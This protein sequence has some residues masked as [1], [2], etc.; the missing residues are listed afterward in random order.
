MADSDIL[1]QGAREHNLREVSLVLPRNQLICFTGVSGSGKSSLAFDTLYAEGQRRYVE[2]LSSFARQF[3]GQMP[4][5]DVDLIAGLSPAISI[6][7]KSSGT[8]PRSTVGTI[9]EI[10]DYLRV[11]FARVGKGHCP[12]CRRPI[13]AQTRVQIIDR[14]GILATG[15]RFL[16][17]APLIRGQ[18][19]EYRDLFEDLLKQGFVRAR[20]DGRVVRLTDDLR[21]DR[22]MRHNIEVVVDRLVAGP[23]LRPRLAE[24]VEAALRLGEGNLIVAADEGDAEKKEGGDAETRRR[25]DSET[26]RRGEEDVS[27]SAR[28][29]LS[30]SLP[31]VPASLASDLALSAHYACTHCQ[32]SFEPPSPQLFSFNSPQGM[33]PE[34]SGLGQIYSFDP[35]RLI[36]D[37]SRSFQQ[38]CIE[39]LGKWREMG[40]WKRHIFRGVAETLERRYGLPPG[41]VLE[42]AWEELD[43][44]ARHA[45][46]WGTGDEHVTFTWRGGASGYKWGGTFEGIIPKFL[47]QYRNTRSRPQRRQLEKYMRVLGCGRCQGRRLNAQAC[48]VTITTA[49]EFP[50]AVREQSL[51]EVCQLSVSAAAD[52]LSALKLDA[53]GATIAAEAVKEIRSRLQFLKNVGLEYLA[54]DRTAPTLSGGEMQRIRLAGQI[55]CGLVGV[56]YIL[57]EPSIGLHPRDNDKLL[58]TLAQLRDQ[59]NTVVVVEHDED[60]MRAAD[61]IVDFGPGPGVRGGNVVAAGSIADV[62]AAEESLTGAYLS[63]RR[64]IDVPAVRRDCCNG[65]GKLA[66]RGARHNNLKN[67]DVE[68][69]LGVFVCVTGV[70]GSGKSSLVN[71]ILVETLRRDLNAG[72]G[73]PGEFDKLEGIEHLDKM[74]AIDQSP[75]GRTPRSNPATYIKVFDEIRRLYTQLPEAKAKGFEPGRFSFNVSGGRCE[76]CE[77]NGSTK[78]EMDFLADIWVTC[79]VCEGHRFNRETLQVRYKGKSIAEVLEM[80]VQEALTHFENIPAVADKLRTLHAVGLDYVKLGQPSPTLSGGEAQRIKLARELVKKSTGRTLYLLDEPTTGLHFADIQLLLTVLHGFVEAGNTVLVVE[81]NTEVIKTADWIIDLGPEGGAGGGQIIATGTPEQVAENPAS[82]TGQV[83]KRWLAKRGKGERE[84]GRRGEGEKS[85]PPAPLSP[86]PTP[87]RAELAKAIKVRGARQHNLKGIDVDIP[88]DQMTVCCGP[89]GSGKT[90]LA[91]DTIYAEGQRRY[92]ESLSSYARQFV[93]KMQKPRLDHIEGLSPAIAIEQKHAGHSPRSTVGTV[94]EIYDYLR[95]I[96]SRLGQPYC[97]ACDLRV[98]TQTADEIIDKIMQR[99]A[100]TRLYLMAPLEIEVGEKYEVLW[101]ELLAAGYVRVR[102]DGQTHTL[103]QMPQI[104]RR[105]KHDVEVVIDRVTVWPDG[106]SPGGA[107]GTPGRSRVAGSVE[108]ALAKGRGVLRVTEPRD[109]VPEARWPVEVHSQ[110]FACQKCGRSFEPLSPHNFSFNSTLGWC[111]AC[112]GLG[113]QT[114]TNPAALLRDPKLSLAQGAVG[115]W[116]GASNRLFQR[117]LESFT[118]GAGIPIDVPYDQLGGK[119][120]RLIMHG[121]GDQWFDVNV[122]GTRRVPN[123]DD[124]TRRLPD[125]LPLP[126][127]RFQYKG[128]YPALEEASRVSPG[129]RGR[130]EHL[131]DEVDCTVCGGSR[132]RDD[133]AAVRFRGRTIDEIC[134]QPLGKLLADLRAWKPSATEQKIAGE[135]YR[136]ICNRTQF[137]VDVG[138]DYLTLA[139]PA[140]SLSGGEMQRI[141][142]AAQ[143]GSG[144]CG[145]LYVLDEPTIGLHPRDNARLLDALK[146][147][148]DLGNTLLLVEHDREVIANADKLLDFGPAAGRHGG[149]IVA[150][151][152]PAVVGKRRG[153]VTGPYLTGKKAIAVPT[154]RRMVGGGSGEGKKEKKGRKGVGEKGRKGEANVSPVPSWLEIRGARQNNLKNIDVKIPLGTF[155]VVTGPSGSGKSSLVEDVL[156]ASLARTLHRAKTFPGAHDSI[157]GIEQINK[158]IRVDQQPLGQTPSSNPATFTGALDLIRALFAQLP[159][160]KL[161]GYQPRRFSFN[162]PGGRC[163]KCEGNGQLRIEMHFLP[164]VWVECDT[165]HGQRYNE[166][167]LS[168]RYHGK[169]IAEVLDMPCGEAVQL[170][171]SIPKIRRILQTLCD[172]GLGYV[173]LGQPAPTLSGGE[174]QRVKLAAEL[175]RPDTGNTLYLLD[176]PTTGLHFDDLAKLL[177]VLNR[178]VELGNT[179]VVI[180]HNLDVVKTADWVIDMGPE[181]GEEGGYVVDAGTPED[182]AAHAAGQRKGEGEKG[183]KREREMRISP[184]LPFSPSYLRSYTGEALVPVL[185]AGPHAPRKLFDFAGTEA[186]HEG[187]REIAE[188]G[189]D[190]R[191]PWEIDGRH[192]HTVARV[193][194]NGKPCRWEGRILGDVIDRIQNQSELFSETDW[195][196]RSVVEIRAAKKADG[197]FFHAITGEEWLLKMKFRTARNTFSRDDLLRRLDLKPLNDMPELPLYGTEPRVKLR[198]LRGPWQ[199]VEVR[200]NSYSE[201]DRPEFW[202]FIDQAVGGF[203][204]YSQQAKEQSDILQPWKQLGRKWHF[205]RRGFPLGGKVEWEMEVLEEL[206][207]LL[208]ETAP[209]GQLLWNN[210]QVVPLYVPQ[211]REAWAAVQTKK[212]DAVYLHLTGPKGRFA[213]G[214]I[215]GLGFDAQVDGEK[216]GMDVLRIKFRSTE[217]LRRGE[218]AAFL[219]EHLAAL[220]KKE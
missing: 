156:Y 75:I 125:T 76:A 185:A 130:L 172:V 118:R 25:G 82:F 37:P 45:L 216:T 16:V 108:A 40:R 21:L 105:R 84:K 117:M 22:Q 24:A 181:A 133:A 140:P 106:R 139:R 68:I 83:L 199:E 92:V 217:D 186:Q 150:E 7:Q 169:S 36:P 137:L 141:R 13:T 93:D 3:L 28:P 218:L 113:M 97:P 214:R 120:R 135:V 119:H 209:Y 154:N 194:R 91:M 95:I 23:K 30:A 69:P 155:T 196:S 102:I 32:K 212:L 1:I 72:L 123:P 197:W 187:D 74:I 165:C 201:I 99:P 179:V 89:S 8:N 50:A 4:K 46:L 47:A 131:V 49:A 205:A 58:E 79:P 208:N 168:V 200:V 134:R 39:L 5:P 31:N 110:H 17:L 80:D 81:H 159:E 189:Q 164:D 59:G 207:E 128:L 26:R 163:E 188:L 180:E 9:T 152:S 146:K 10:Y 64:Q 109:D 51:P 15:T 175:S 67:I 12:E 176:E 96:V 20:V 136:E 192:W 132:L 220:E 87:P 190:A 158:V 27:A 2:S 14:I 177:D 61:H 54:L 43:Q 57:D 34:C 90:S 35:E 142:L 174:A 213:Q 157:I 107:P 198:S 151:G 115:L 183:R 71:D 149:Q 48:A 191:M 112:E 56:L 121:T 178:L 65:R 94:T 42:T 122:S 160:A 60:T 101:E 103:D 202:A 211:Q 127:F 145:V 86:F 98:G 170:F 147:L 184:P 111:P 173:T 66:I 6:S 63:G 29:P 19:G 52:F 124:G 129:F 148:R 167:T 182:I 143:V 162:V 77:G 116:P 210:K 195:N 33:C 62:I 114:G 100:G 161:R 215:T 104:D 126:S 203:G 166:E 11:L 88:R 70:S 153:S 38:G 18:K 44:R 55:G 85:S 171:Q 78:L 206:I 138:L 53:T 193:G 219:K 73:N 204:K 41:G 144:L